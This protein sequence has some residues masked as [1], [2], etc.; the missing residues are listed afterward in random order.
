MTKQ[1]IEINNSLKL[2]SET[3]QYVYDAFNELIFSPDTR[4]LGKLLARTLLYNQVKNVPGDIVECGLFKGSGV[5][6]WLK[7]KKLLAPT[8]LWKIIGFDY[9]DTDSLLNSLSGNDKVRMTELFEDSGYK[10]DEAAERLLHEKIAAAGF[11][12]NDYELV[13]GDIL[14]TAQKFVS[15]RPGFKISLLY[16]DLDTEAATYE[17]LSAF[18]DRISVGGLVVFDEYGMHQWSE[19]LGADKFF[20]SKRVQIK[21]LDYRQ[22]TAYVVK[23]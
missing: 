20:N 2:E 7:I 21:S 8:S 16:L 11:R 15:E 23:E 19:S 14:D 10:H 5:L 9:F 13:K 22:P 12:E 6:S 17:V 1:Y 3:P 18:W 4:V